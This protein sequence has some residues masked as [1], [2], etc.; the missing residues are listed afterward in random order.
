MVNTKL[1]VLLSLLG[2]H[3]ITSMS[4]AEFMEL[5]EENIR[6]NLHK[7]LLGGQ[8]PLY[9]AVRKNNHESEQII[10]RLVDLKADPDFSDGRGWTPLRHAVNNNKQE[11]VDLLIELKAN[12]HEEGIRPD[13]TRVSSLLSDVLP[14]DHVGIA[15]SLISAGAKIGLE[16]NSDGEIGGGAEIGAEQCG[17]I[18]SPVGDGPGEAGAGIDS[19]SQARTGQCSILEEAIR[20]RALKIAKLLVAS[21]APVHVVRQ[22][23]SAIIDLAVVWGDTALAQALID[24]GARV[25]FETVINAAKTGNPKKVQIIFRAYRAGQRREEIAGRVSQEEFENSVVEYG[26]VGAAWL[27]VAVF[28]WQLA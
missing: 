2:A 5:S 17:E 7:K 20:R 24:K 27:A 3:N 23:G 13:G 26:F 10:R 28:A 11:M 19:R 8:T 21:G 18:I 15:Q 25:D 4:L 1:L 12:V 6:D 22:D 16:P 9:T 14:D